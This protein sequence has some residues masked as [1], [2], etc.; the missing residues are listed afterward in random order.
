MHGSL[1]NGVH[2]KIVHRNMDSGT[3]AE[4]LACMLGISSN[5]APFELT[6]KSW[7]I[8]YPFKKQKIA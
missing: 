1:A 7:F 5:N 8:F 4:F 3:V 2:Y 6:C